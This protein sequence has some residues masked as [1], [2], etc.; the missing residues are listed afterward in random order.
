MPDQQGV[1]KKQPGF[2][3]IKVNDPEAIEVNCDSRPSVMYGSVSTAV[4]SDR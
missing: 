1:R 2:L 4:L 3:D